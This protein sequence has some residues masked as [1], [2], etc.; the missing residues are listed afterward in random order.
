MKRLIL[1][2]L[3]PLV[4]TACSNVKKTLGMERSQPD[5]FA[6]V[7]RAPLTMPP[8]F[9]LMPPQP[10]VPRPQ[11]TKTNVTA[12]GLILGTQT[13]K[14]TEQTAS[15]SQNVDAGIADKSLDNSAE[16][17]LLS[18]ANTAAAKPVKSDT[19]RDA[20]VLK[21][22]DE[23]KRLQQQNINTTTPPSPVM[24]NAQ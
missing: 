14:T 21:P 10:G 22:T 23:S 1:I 3:L 9:N 2:M 4:F 24:Q 12:Q 20:S 18:D 11:E 6:V 15:E 13:D 17:G 19:A 7:E 5:E 8:N 16:A